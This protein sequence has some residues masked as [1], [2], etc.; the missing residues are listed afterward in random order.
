MMLLIAGLVWREGQPIFFAH[1]RIGRHGQLFKCLK[2]RSMVPN[3]AEVLEDLL[4]R[5]PAARAEW[6]R[7]YKLKTIPGSPASA[8]SS[9][10]AAWTSCRSSGTSSRAR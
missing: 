3:A 7:D 4:S 6:E 10:K 8:T 9:E 5:D 1:T 2:F